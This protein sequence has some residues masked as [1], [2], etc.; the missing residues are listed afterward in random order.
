MQLVW[1]NLG[2]DGEN[3]PTVYTHKKFPAISYT[4]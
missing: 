1:V 3:D 4:N 2:T